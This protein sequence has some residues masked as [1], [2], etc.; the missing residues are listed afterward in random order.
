MLCILHCLSTDTLNAGF[1]KVGQGRGV[2]GGAWGCPPSHD[3]FFEPL[4][5]PPFMKADA[6][7]PWGAPLPLKNE[8]PIEK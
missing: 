2:G 3:F 5:P 4:P 7:P 6:P 1:P 8:A